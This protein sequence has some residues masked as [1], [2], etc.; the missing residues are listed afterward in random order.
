[1]LLGVMFLLSIFED[2]L[3]ARDI[4]LAVGTGGLCLTFELVDAVGADACTGFV[5]LA[6]LTGVK[7]E[8]IDDC[9]AGGGPPA[10]GCILC[11]G[12]MGLSSSP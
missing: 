5:P 7:K 3:D 4:G 6:L 9:R 12:S 11:A 10:T 2:E 1:V 8:A